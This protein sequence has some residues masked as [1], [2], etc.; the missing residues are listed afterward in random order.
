MYKAIA[1]RV[2]V[3]LCDDNVNSSVIGPENKYRNQGIILSVGEKVQ[4]LQAGDRIIFH[5]FDEL[6]LPEK[7]CAVVREKSVLGILTNNL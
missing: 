5:Q 6:M 3:K 4:S 7:D 2:V 1:D